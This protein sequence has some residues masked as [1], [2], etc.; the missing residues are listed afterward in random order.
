M[1]ALTGSQDATAKVWDLGDYDCIH[2]LDG[3]ARA[4]FVGTL[5]ERRYFVNAVCVTPDGC[6][7]FEGSGKSAKLWN[8]ADGKCTGLNLTHTNYVTDVCVSPDG[9][10]ALTGS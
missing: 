10:R 4:K 8:L 3:R 9:Q 1:L 7:A 6:Y 2:K 5:A